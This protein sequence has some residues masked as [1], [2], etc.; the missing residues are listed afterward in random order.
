[1]GIAGLVNIF[2]PEKIILGGPMSIAGDY[3]LPAI[4]ESVEKHSLP[5]IIQ[6][7][8]ILLSAF[9][10]DASVIGSIAIVVDDILSNPTRVERR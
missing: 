1:M 2:N 6:Q 8:E 4:K 9:G 7:M 5:E 3:L 10:S